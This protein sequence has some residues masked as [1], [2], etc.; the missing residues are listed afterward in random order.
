M[1]ATIVGRSRVEDG[2]TLREVT[3]VTVDQELSREDGLAH[4]A[5]DEDRR[6]RLTD[7]RG[8]GTPTIYGALSSVDDRVARWAGVTQVIRPFCSGPVEWLGCAGGGER[9]CVRC[10]QVTPMIVGARSSARLSVSHGDRPVTCQDP[11]PK[12]PE[13]PSVKR[14]RFLS[15]RVSLWS[16]QKEPLATVPSLYKSPGLPARPPADRSRAEAL[17]DPTGNRSGSERHRNAPED[18]GLDGGWRREAAG[19]DVGL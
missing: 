16:A 7:S 4:E 3:Y 17:S 8:Y 18:G 12:Y 6:W 19:G 1:T 10:E 5:R 15:A 13:S 2:R 14:L 11:C 9:P